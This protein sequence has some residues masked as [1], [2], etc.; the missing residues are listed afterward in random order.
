MEM[1]WRFY[2]REVVGQQIQSFLAQIYLC[3]ELRVFRQES[4]KFLL[5]FRAE[6][7]KGITCY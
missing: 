7:V 1:R 3:S 5:L 4:L 2:F 6:A